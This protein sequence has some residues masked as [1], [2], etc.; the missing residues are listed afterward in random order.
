MNHSMRLRVDRL[1]MR[2][3]AWSAVSHGG[4]HYETLLKSDN[5]LV[6]L[7][8]WDHVQISSCKLHLVRPCQ[9]AI[10]DMIDLSRAFRTR[11]LLALALDVRLSAG[12]EH[13]IRPRNIVHHLLLRLGHKQLKPGELCCFCSWQWSSRRHRG[14]REGERE[15]ERERE[16][17]ECL[18]VSGG[19]DPSPQHHIA[20]SQDSH[21]EILCRKEEDTFRHYFL[22]IP[23]LILALLIHH[24]FTIIEVCWTFS[25]YLEAVAILPQLL[26]LQ[27]SRN[28]DN[29]TGNYVFFLG[30]VP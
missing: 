17:D 15:R 1:Q 10:D 22:I 30:Y 28:I 12:D 29:L 14:G 2:R 19:Y 6:L 9:R 25:I 16:R 20:A 5:F 3:P 7:F 13:L 8:C 11:G 4:A 21:H 23:C 26:L 18:Q 27:R 24:S